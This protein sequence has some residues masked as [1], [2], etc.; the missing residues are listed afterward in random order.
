MGKME[1]CKRC[2]KDFNT[3]SVCNDCKEDLVA[4]FNGTVNWETAYQIELEQEEIG[5]LD[6]NLDL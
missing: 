6:L 4:S 2:G 5:K 1:K 3:N